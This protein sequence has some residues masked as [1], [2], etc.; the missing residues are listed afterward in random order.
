MTL[1]CNHGFQEFQ[2]LK[3][4]LL[5]MVRLMI[6]SVSVVPPEGSAVGFCSKKMPT[7][8]AKYKNPILDFIWGPVTYRDMPVTDDSE[9]NF[10]P[11]G[12]HCL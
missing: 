11:Q 10:L 8:P 4:C 7:W 1:L 12:V 6:A 5:I 9:M 3:H 2:L